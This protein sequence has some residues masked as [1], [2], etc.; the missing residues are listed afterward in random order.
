MLGRQADVGQ[1]L[2][3]QGHRLGFR[4]IFRN[5]DER[6]MI[7]TVAGPGFLGNTLPAVRQRSEGGSPSIS[8]AQQL[9]VCSL[10]NSFTFDWLVRVKVTYH[11][12]FFTVYQLPIPRLTK[13]DSQ[14]HPLVQ[15]AAKLICTT[16]EFDALAKEVGIQG[17]QHGERDEA[18]RQ[19]IRAEID[20]IVA[21]RNS[22]GPL[23]KSRRGI[24]AES[25]L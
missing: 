4:D 23:Q 13:K 16:P 3:Y 25:S 1:V 5:T 20:G 8:N 17:H 21:H 12:N 19:K 14:F 15:R 10:F 7:S 18:E 6:T 24:L 9:F 22:S 11:L 2:D